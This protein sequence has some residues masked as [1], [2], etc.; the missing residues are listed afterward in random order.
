MT[1]HRTSTEL[2]PSITVTSLRLSDNSKF[3]ALDNTWLSNRA[4][5]TGI[6]L[7]IAIAVITEKN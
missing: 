4:L 5:Y 1:V 2:Y 3:S 6:D 7:F